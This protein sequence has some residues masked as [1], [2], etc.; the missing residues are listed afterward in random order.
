MFP[1]NKTRFKQ[2]PFLSTAE[3]GKLF[4]AYQQNINPEGV[5]QD[6]QT[7]L[8]Y[9]SSGH[10]A[11]FMILLKLFNECRPELHQ[12][13][14]ELQSNLSNFMN[15][16]HLKIK[17]L[18]ENTGTDEKAR[19][20]ELRSNATSSW[21]YLGLN[22]TD[23]YLLDIGVIL[24]VNQS[25]VRFT[26]CV[27]LRVSIDNVWP[28]QINQLSMKD[29]HLFDPIKIL[30]YGL[31]RIYPAPITD[32]LVQNKYGLAESSIQAAL[33]SAFNTLL[34]T[35]MICLFEPRPRIGNS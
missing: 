8:M 13:G 12:W 25:M 14:L 17:Y 11:F 23:K 16:T 30:S 34:P 29:V 2:I 4:E 9:E 24:P 27:L 19:V 21:N 3:M 1:L 33:Y 32:L 15:G 7:K 31:E 5:P 35:S 18:L 28:R 22:P 26:S 10:P 6:L 20:H